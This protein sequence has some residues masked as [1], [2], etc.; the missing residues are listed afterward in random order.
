VAV[1]VSTQKSSVALAG[2]QGEEALGLQPGDWSRMRRALWLILFLSGS[3]VM[4]GEIAADRAA[5][6]LAGE[7]GGGRGIE[8]GGEA[9]SG[10]PRYKL[11]AC[12]LYRDEV[13][14]HTSIVTILSCSRGCDRRPHRTP[15][16]R[17]WCS[18]H[19]R[20]DLKLRLETE[21]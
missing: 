19:Q 13:S 14:C 3:A 9:Q 8:W 2:L 10:T 6:S 16:A 18:L 11:V 5:P 20:G 4:T 17:P 7:G 1:L 12:T 15:A 21:T